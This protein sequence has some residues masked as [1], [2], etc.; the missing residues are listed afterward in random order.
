[1]GSPRSP[2]AGRCTCC[3]VAAGGRESPRARRG[4]RWRSPCRWSRTLRRGGERLARA[5]GVTKL[6][7]Y[8]RSAAGFSLRMPSLSLLL[9][10][11][12]TQLE[13]PAQAASPI[14][15]GAPPSGSSGEGAAT[16]CSGP[17][18][19]WPVGRSQP[20]DH[21]PRGRW[22][23][24]HGPH[25]AGLLPRRPRLGWGVS[26]ATLQETHRL[27]HT[28]GSVCVGCGATAAQLRGPRG[29]GAAG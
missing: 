16:R 26:L 8:S 13:I 21:G 29:K 4:Q 3:S 1:M 12:S 23:V 22:Q 20:L 19:L 25:P 11:C 6:G 14:L 18:R 10:L 27:R 28:S 9:S 24:L 17:S 15:P 5:L 7:F 2:A